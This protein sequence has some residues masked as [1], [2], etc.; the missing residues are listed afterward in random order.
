MCCYRELDAFRGRKRAEGGRIKCET[1]PVAACWEE[2]HKALKPFNGS[3]SPHRSKRQLNMPTGVRVAR[4]TAILWTFPHN[5][6][7]ARF[8]RKVAFCVFT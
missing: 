4:R 2:A 1:C 8:L 7:R 3:L 5:L 6:G